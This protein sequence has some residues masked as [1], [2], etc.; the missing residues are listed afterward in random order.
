MEEDPGLGSTEDIELPV[1][2]QQPAPNAAPAETPNDDSDEE[3]A[4]IFHDA[5]SDVHD[6]TNDLLA[7]VIQSGADVPAPASSLKRVKKI[8]VSLNET[9]NSLIGLGV[10]FLAV[11]SVVY[12]IWTVHK[13]YYDFYYERN[14]SEHRHFENMKQADTSKQTLDPLPQKCKS[15]LKEG[16]SPPFSW[17]ATRSAFSLAAE[18]LSQ[19]QNEIP[20]TLDSRLSN[21]R[22][23]VVFL[24]GASCAVL[25]T[26]SAFC[27]AKYGRPAGGVW[28]QTVRLPEAW[29]ATELARQNHDWK[30]RRRHRHI[31]STHVDDG[32]QVCSRVK[33]DSTLC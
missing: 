7:P 22:P 30:L 11:I 23:T 29:I 3:D 17:H 27:I 18:S 19:G 31:T 2:I 12:T 32:C 6:S 1:R 9:T 28:I 8:L 14:V 33:T 26:G 5:V 10:F 13:D 16:I 4:A 25:L 24:S 15:T 20:S 21:M